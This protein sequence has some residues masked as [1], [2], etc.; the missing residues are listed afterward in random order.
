MS[1]ADD[2]ITEHLTSQRDYLTDV[3]RVEIAG[4]RKSLDDAVRELDKGRAP[5]TIL[6]GNFTRE[7]G[8]MNGTAAEL[9]AILD[10]LRYIASAED[11]P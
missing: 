10:T 1:A 5:N 8:H 11:T 3:L 4:A 9:D 7:A 6:L 2:K